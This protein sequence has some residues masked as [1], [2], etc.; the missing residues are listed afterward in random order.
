[1]CV[2]LRAFGGQIRVCGRSNTGL[3]A[4]KYGLWAVK[5]GLFLGLEK[6]GDEI[7]DRG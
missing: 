1:M 4:V 5:Y 3:W 2:F 7:A 6:T